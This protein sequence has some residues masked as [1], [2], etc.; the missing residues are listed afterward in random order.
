M[1]MVRIYQTTQPQ[2]M[3]PEKGFV[4]FDPLKQTS[5]VLNSIKLHRNTRSLPRER[6]LSSSGSSSSYSLLPTA[7]AVSTACD[8]GIMVDR[9][10]LVFSLDQQLSKIDNNNKE[11]YGRRRFEWDQLL[12]MQCAQQLLVGGGDCNEGCL[13]NITKIFKWTHMYTQ[14]YPEDREER[15]MLYEGFD[16]VV[17]FANLIDLFIRDYQDYKEKF[18]YRRHM[19]VLVI[20]IS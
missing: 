9:I 19:D 1:M 7:Q 20:K 3:T 14:T 13:R 11:V 4:F 15:R 16:A 2:D 10:N 18:R 5:K 8:P 12:K 17:S 6:K